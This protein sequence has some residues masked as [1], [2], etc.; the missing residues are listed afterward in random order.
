MIAAIQSIVSI[1]AMIFIG[2]L[3]A[4]KKIFNDES[5]SLFSKLVINLSLPLLIMK[6]IVEKFT[7]QSLI[8]SGSGLLVSFIAIFLSY[9]IGMI[10]FKIIN[11]EG[12]GNS[13]YTMMF[14]FSNTIFIGLPVC[15]SV[16]GE[17]SIPYALL[18]DFANSMI[19][20]TLGIYKINEELSTTNQGSNGKNKV[21]SPP[22]L[23]F[24]FS[25]TLV[26]LNIKLPKF[27]LDICGYIGNIT[28]PLSMFIIGTMLANIDIKSYK[29]NLTILFILLGKFFI[30]PGIIIAALSLFSTPALLKST[31]V[32]QASMPIMT[33]TAIVAKNYNI[34][35]KETSYMVGLSTLLS[36]LILPL[37]VYIISTL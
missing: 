11:K 30:V 22:L 32:L 8:E 23:S 18:Y 14:T 2:V 34:A 33:Q 16:L 19:F 6:N 5:S 35:E 9:I 29:F 3:L 28:T 15:I 12:K 4:K 7:K 26:A 31:Y 13:I 27:I 20:W 36:L 10:I 1:F 25:L 17:D 24:I 37:Y 21:L